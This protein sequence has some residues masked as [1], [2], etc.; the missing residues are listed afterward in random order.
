MPR[1][2]VYDDEASAI[3]GLTLLCVVCVCMTLFV[4]CLRSSSPIYVTKRW[5]ERKRVKRMNM[6][7]SVRFWTYVTITAVLWV[8]VAY[9]TM[10]MM[11]A[12]RDGYFDPFE[13]LQV[14]PRLALEDS[15]VIKSSY[16]RLSKLYHP[17]RPGGDENKF[18]R[19]AKAYKA[20]ASEEGRKNYLKYGHP[21]GPQSLAMRMALPSF[22]ENN[23]KSFV[24]VY[25]LGLCVGV[26]ML[27]YIA[28][29]CV[30]G[31]NAVVVKRDALC[32]AFVRDFVTEGYIGD[33]TMKKK[34]KVPNANDMLIS[35][36][37]VL[38]TVIIKTSN[39]R[40]A[41]TTVQEMSNILSPL[42]IDKNGNE[43]Y[44]A[45]SVLLKLHL[46]NLS[47]PEMFK[48]CPDIVGGLYDEIALNFEPMIRA[49]IEVAL[50]SKS[51]AIADHAINLTTFLHQGVQS[52]DA[53]V[54]KLQEEA[55]KRENRALP[56]SLQDLKFRVFTDGEDTICCN[57]IVTV[58]IEA[59]LPSTS[60]K[61][62]VRSLFRFNTQKDA[63]RM[64]EKERWI[65]LVRCESADKNL[66]VCSGVL[67]ED[68]QKSGVV[69]CLLQCRAPRKKGKWVLRIAVKSTTYV[70]PD[71]IHTE[72]LD[73][74]TIEEAE[75]QQGKEE[76]KE[77][78]RNDD[79][80]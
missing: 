12:R 22:V 80:D 26:P 23:Q 56:C 49:M 65:V 63:A 8:V 70:V 17:D 60:E 67:T 62:R 9:A 29:R 13:I 50:R 77:E 18:V 64:V 69:S 30:I 11:D 36:T 76:E 33:S 19:I 61:Q 78:K 55:C 42:K 44:R 75:D 51:Y 43:E 41:V 3:F 45:V 1:K 72:N 57:D 21:D 40:D 28:K 73:V 68:K 5:G 48:K 25:L 37:K 38:S 4:M 10:N 54:F 53:Q 66:I 2:I 7:N 52:K 47:D 71:I 39:Q 15:K 34:L 74:I 16:R 46:S 58:S 24:T 59:K 32:R 79:D 31:D 20:L 14:D 6:A 35:F 27:L